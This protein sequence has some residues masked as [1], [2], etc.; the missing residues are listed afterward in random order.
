MSNLF[1]YLGDP[2]RR[3][4]PHGDGPS[5]P[6]LRRRDR[7][8]RGHAASRTSASAIPGRGRGRCATSI[9]FIP[10]GQSVALVGQ[11][12]AGK[13]TFIK[14][15]T[16][17]Y[18]PTEGRILLDGKDLR[19]WD[20]RDAARA[21]RRRL[22]GLQPVPAQAPRER[23]RSAASSTSRTRRASSARSSAAARTRSSRTLPA[24]PRDA[25]RPLVPGRRRALGRAVAE[26]R[27]RAR[28]HARGG[29]HPRAR[30]ADRRARRRGRARRLRALPRSS[31]QGA[32]RS[33]SRTASR[34]CA[35]PIASSCS[36]GG[37]IVEEGTHDELVAAGGRYAHLFALQA[38]GYR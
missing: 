17:L 26:G 15:L 21:H 32:R 28:L 35:W 33:S 20:E 37:A 9:L 16:R 34:P 5:W 31:P 27:A 2:A 30:R 8:R 12:G 3:T 19:D 29:R 11:N 25:A 7:T 1:A 13:T 24:G 18:E 10:R 14:L 23:R 4:P 22:P 38:E 6:P 36:R